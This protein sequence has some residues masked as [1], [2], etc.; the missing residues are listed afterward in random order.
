[1]L[2]GFQN[3]SRDL[4]HLNSGFWG[5]LQTMYHRQGNKW[6][7][8]RLWGCVSAER[9][10]SNTCCNFWRRKTFY[11]SHRNTVCVKIYFFCS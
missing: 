6:V 8:K 7:A 2:C 10:H 5:R 4:T 9:Q 11:Y 3:N 1:L